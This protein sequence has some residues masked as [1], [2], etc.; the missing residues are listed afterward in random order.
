MLGH[1]GSPVTIGSWGCLLTC[2]AMTAGALGH[3]ITPFELNRQMIRK[4]G[5]WQGH[6]TEWDA[7]ASVYSDLAFEGKEDQ[8]PHITTRIDAHLANRVPVPVL[9]DRTPETRYNDNDQ[10]WVLV[11]ARHDINDYWVYDPLD[12]EGDPVSL[13][14]RYG[15]SDSSVR[16]AIRSAIFYRRA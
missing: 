13:M 14:G 11:V 16:N 1:P 6:F 8:H 4:G 9:V 7:L 3:Q 10:H 5:F 15:R 12:L 2:F